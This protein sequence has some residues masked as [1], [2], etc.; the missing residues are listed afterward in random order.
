MLC[1]Y[2]NLC[3]GILCGLVSITA[4]GSVIDPW[5]GIVV[6]A[7][8]A[9]IFFQMEQMI[10]KLGVDDGVGASAMHGCV[11][12]WGTLVPGLFAR[13]PHVYELMG[14]MAKDEV[15]VKGL[16]YGGNGKLLGCQLIGVG[17]RASASGLH[18]SYAARMTTTLNLQGWFVLVSHG[19]TVRAHDTTAFRPHWLAHCHLKR[20]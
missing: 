6:G 8:G 16:F 18:T 7:I 12:F 13:S 5:A 4:G 2:G 20:G 19:N 17:P 3:N 15:L 9:L 10:A 14:N 11:G 1:S